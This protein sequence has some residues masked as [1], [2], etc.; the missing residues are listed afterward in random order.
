D[1]AES[2]YRGRGQLPAHRSVAWPAQDVS[3]A[4]TGHFAIELVQQPSYE[5]SL[6]LDC[7]RLL[8]ADRA[9]VQM[10]FQP[11]LGRRITLPVQELP[12]QSVSRMH[13]EAP[14]ML[15]RG[16]RSRARAGCRRSKGRCPTP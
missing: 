10:G 8:L 2:D 3:Y 6:A 5:R 9:A 12:P 15:L 16:Q 1:H 14:G 11:S 13:E 7:R 4:S